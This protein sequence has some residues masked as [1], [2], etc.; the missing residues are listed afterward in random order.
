MENLL[1]SFNVVLPLFLCIVLGY[2]LR[3]IGMLDPAALKCL[4]KLGFKVFLPIYLFNTIYAT[5]ISAAFNPRLIATGVGGLLL[6]Y[7]ILMLLIPRIEKENPR[8]GVMIQGIFRSNFALYGLPVALS[9]CGEAN[10]GPTSLMIAIMV[11]VYNILAVITLETFRG[12][13]PNPRKMLRGVITNPLIISSM[14][15]VIA[16]LIQLPVPTAVQKGLTDLGRV[17]TPLALVTLGGE[18][19]FR[20]VSAFRRQ[21]SIVVIG[22][23][24]LGAL[25]MVA[26]GVM[27]GFRN[28]ML[29]PLLIMFG[30][31]T[32]VSSFTMAQQ[33]DG[34]SELAASVVVF[35]TA[36]SILTIFLWVF[37]LKQFG[38]I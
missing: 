22:K 25:A 34:D 36:L 16:N 12:G 10:I 1:L 28:E 26:V 23:L 21:L 9:L 29:V 27:M 6:I 3:R 37:V 5:D 8:R 24:I 33:M 32:A 30:A 7:A 35:T 20:S 15:G 13:K 17:A 14:L 31:P 11:P 38:L 2:F 18:F 19:M 4:N